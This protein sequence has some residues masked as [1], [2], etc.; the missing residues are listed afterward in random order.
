MESGDHSKNGVSPKSLTSRGNLKKWTRLNTL[1]TTSFLMA[2]IVVIMLMQSCAML[3]VGS[4]YVPLSNHS[5]YTSADIQL[6]S[7]P[8]PDPNLPQGY[9]LFQGYLS[10]GISNT[11]F[12]I[13]DD[14]SLAGTYAKL[15]VGGIYFFS[16]GRFQSFLGL[17]YSGQTIVESSKKNSNDGIFY[18]SITPYVGARMYIT[19]RIAINGS[20]G[21]Q[22]GGLAI[23]KDNELKRLAKHT[24][25]SGL[26]PSI[27]VTFVLQKK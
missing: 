11:R 22:W 26:T 27:G 3:T 8:D 23:G 4:S 6:Y 21:Y 13:T 10:T 16:T 2:G 7:D 17:E 18:N 12:N 15:G 20:L 5:A 14:D 19:N 1:K 25:F 9:N 24:G